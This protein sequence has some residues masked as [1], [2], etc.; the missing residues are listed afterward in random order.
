MTVDKKLLQAFW[1][2]TRKEFV[3]LTGDELT[4]RSRVGIEHRAKALRVGL[5]TVESKK[6]GNENHL[7]IYEITKLGIAFLRSDV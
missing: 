6:Q 3:P 4:I 2:R 5:I 7:Y 1:H